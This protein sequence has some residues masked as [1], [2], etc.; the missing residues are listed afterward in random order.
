MPFDGLPLAVFYQPL[1]DVAKAILYF[2]HDDV[3]FG[4]G[5][6]IVGLT[7]I[8]RLAIV[9]LTI[10]Q[11]KSMNAMRVL[12]PQ[13]KE[14]QEKYKSDR[15]RMNQEM[16]KFFKENKVNPFASCLPLILQLPVFLAL[17]RLLRSA[18][19]KDKLEHSAS[20]GWLF[21]TDLA[22]KET[23][24]ALIVLIVLYIASQMAASLVM[25]SASTGDKTQQRI[26][27][28]FPLMIVPFII[29]FPAGLVVYWITT[30]F[31]TLG[32]QIVVRKLSPPMPA[33]PAGAMA[34]VGTGKGRG[35]DADEAEPGAGDGGAGK[36]AARGRRAGRSSGQATLTKKKP[37]PPPRRKKRR[38]R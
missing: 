28:F 31:W 24:A 7:V 38:R 17:F 23:G 29:N 2:L 22:H 16:Q 25:M 19:F 5:M 11:I 13:I 27:L 36:G 10:R 12:Q 32:Q 30:N 37:P 18:E 34:A 3:G 20:H 21:I 1:V 14:I 9:P 26:F 6:S 35:K 8:V 4:W 33:V 15:Q